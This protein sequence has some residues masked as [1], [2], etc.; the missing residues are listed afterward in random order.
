MQEGHQGTYRHT[1]SCAFTKLKITPRCWEI[2][3]CKIHCGDI[4]WNTKVCQEK[5]SIS[6]ETVWKKSILKDHPFLYLVM[7]LVTFVCK[8]TVPYFDAINIELTLAPWQHHCHEIQIAMSH[9]WARTISPS[10]W[11][12]VISSLAQPGWRRRWRH[13]LPFNLILASAFKA[14]LQC[15]GN[16]NTVQGW[17]QKSIP[18]CDR[19]SD[20]LWDFRII[21]LALSL[22]LRTARQ[23]NVWHLG[24]CI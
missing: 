20:S 16:K 15:T 2:Q 23:C 13:R 12:W 10:G 1:Q 24:V 19:N 11:Q 21:G 9:H 5:L 6:L 18:L 14:L 4:L 17:E 22:P 8:H 3:N 7:P